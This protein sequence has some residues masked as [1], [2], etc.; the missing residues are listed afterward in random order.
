MSIAIVYPSIGRNDVDSDIRQWVTEIADAF[1]QTFDFAL[2]QSPQIT[3]EPIE[4]QADY[5]ISRPSPKALSITFE[6]WNHV[7]ES[8]PNLD[9][10]TLNYS[11]I[12]GQRLAL[13]DIFARPDIALTLMSRL[14]RSRLLERYGM[15]RTQMLYR[16]TEP[17][18]ENFSSLTLTPEGIRVNFQPYQVASWEMGVQKVEIPLEDLAQAKPCTVFWGKESVETSHNR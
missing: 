16:G 1:E 6:L 17:L 11:L 13:S 10:I 3:Y 15:G 4:L 8:R 7:G 9:V 14:S 12:N 2:F 5:T 18:V